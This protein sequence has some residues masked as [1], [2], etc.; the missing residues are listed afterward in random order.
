MNGA[1]AGDDPASARTTV[2]SVATSAAEGALTRAGVS[3]THALRAVGAFV[4]VAAVAL[5]RGGYFPGAWGWTILAAAW[6]IAA[7]LLARGGALIARPAAVTAAL[8]AAFTLWTGLS[9]IWTLSP[10]QT[11]LETQRVA[12]YAAV[13][14][15]AALWVRR[16]PAV[17]LGGAWAAIAVVCGWS[18]L[19]RLVPDH[20]G[21]DYVGSGNR[22]ASPIGYWN[23]LGI[24]AAGGAIL[25]L[26]LASEARAR[27]VRAVAA[28]SMPVLVTTLYFTYSRGAWISIA[29]GLLVFAVACPRPA[30]LVAFAAAL[31]PWSAI[32]VWRASVSKPLTIA[33]P[34]LSAAA[35]DGHRL[36]LGVLLA[37]AVSAGVALLLD[38]ADER[39]RL[40]R[41]WVRPAH[42]VLVVGAVV[43]LVAGMARYGSPTTVW[44]KFAT[45]KPAGGQ[46][47]N[48]RLFSVGGNGRVTQWK[49]AWNEVKAHPVAGSGARTYEIYWNRLRPN[50]GHI[51]DVHNL[52][53]QVLAELGIVGLVLL[54]AALAVPLVTGV[55]WRRQPYLAGALG[56]YVA[57]L[58]HAIVDWDWEITGVM[59]PF[60]ICAAVLAS[61]ETHRLHLAGRRVAIAAAVLLGLGGIYSVAARY[62]MRQ[63]SSAISK[64]Q[65][66]K[67]T[68]DANRASDLAP[69]SSEPYLQLGEAELAAGLYPQAQAAFITATKR[70]RSNWVA[71]WDLARASRG[72]WRQDALI[73]VRI[74]NPRAPRATD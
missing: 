16:S 27:W 8:L 66:T 23:S 10:T 43:V 13:F 6:A 73:H 35:H 42:I 59:L 2:S 29:A 5:D 57:Y 24:F 32:A 3:R 36:V 15:A 1:E 12:V 64:Q 60:L 21:V 17:L 45:E 25:A 44:H 68:T 65:W 67:A 71:W 51:R 22:L 74:L 72:G 37:C 20:F 18:L 34:P 26:T 31:A 7:A 11:A 52:Y 54:V 58:L 48:G 41:P 28:A 4:L 33:N 14:L 56:L 62:P 50:T 39:L 38:R 49:V 9:S 70:D 19:T 40:P 53:L 69:W 61:P 63:L 55:R 30:R 47:L 46:T